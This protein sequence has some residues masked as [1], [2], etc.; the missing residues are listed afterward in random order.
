MMVKNNDT[1]QRGSANP[2]CSDPPGA[3]PRKGG[4]PVWLLE[5]QMPQCHACAAPQHP[6]HCGPVATAT[7]SGLRRSITERG[8]AGDGDIASHSPLWPPPNP[9]HSFR[10]VP[11]TLPWHPQPCAWLCP[12][13]GAERCSQRCSELGY[14]IAGF[15]HAERSGGGRKV[16]KHR[17]HSP[18]RATAVPSPHTGWYSGRHRSIKPCAG[19][20][21]L[22]WHMDKGGIWTCMGHPRVQEVGTAT[23]ERAAVGFTWGGGCMQEE[24]ENG[25]Q[26]KSKIAADATARLGP[27]EASDGGLAVSPA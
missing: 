4:A 23:A 5:H 11:T 7:L 14:R 10:G 21:L 15:V 17:G 16:T 6:L 2:L 27:G 26:H 9:G 24:W 3:G 19:T 1:L 12:L 8:H 18:G 20:L 22:G 13:H 25:I